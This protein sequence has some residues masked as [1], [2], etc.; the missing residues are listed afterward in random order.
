[1]NKEQILAKKAEAIKQRDDL[2]AKANVAIG[3]VVAFEH[4]LTEMEQE[5]QQAAKPSPII[6]GHSSD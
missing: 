1:M 5:E 2:A 6:N 4:L 3:I